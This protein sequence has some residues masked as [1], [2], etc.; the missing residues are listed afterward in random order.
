MNRTRL[1]MIGFVALALAA[2]VSLTVYR[3]LNAP[4][5]ANVAPG[6][7]IIIAAANISLGAK[8]EDKH[9][10]VVELPAA[11]LPARHFRQTS[12]ELGRGVIAP[13]AQGDYVLREE[14][15]T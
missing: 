8:I 1:L 2:F 14:L 12:Q 13:I 7:N 5:A 15:G 3:R 11:D 6:D 9:V 10:K 4:R